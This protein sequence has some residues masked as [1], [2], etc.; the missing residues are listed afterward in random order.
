MN[1][2]KVGYLFLMSTLFIT[3]V[4]LT[5][6]YLDRNKMKKIDIGDNAF[7]ITYDSDDRIIAIGNKIA[8]ILEADNL[9]V[10]ESIEAS[11]FKTDDIVRYLENSLFYQVSEIDYFDLNYVDVCTSNPVLGCVNVDNNYDNNSYGISV[12]SLYVYSYALFD[13][14]IKINKDFMYNGEEFV[15]PK[16]IINKDIRLL[17]DKYNINYNN[18]IYF[19]EFSGYLDNNRVTYN[20]MLE[21]IGKKDIYSATFDDISFKYIERIK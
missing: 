18:R 5:S 20:I 1:R 2:L 19:I 16:N 3:F 14:E 13:R 8:Y 6:S 21:V 10:G 15:F 17:F 4:F 7:G 11:K 9:K 12:N